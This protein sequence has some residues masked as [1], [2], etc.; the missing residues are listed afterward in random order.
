MQCKY[1]LGVDV[2][3]TKIAH[4]PH[5]YQECEE[6]R[7]QDP[8][9][10]RLP[11]LDLLKGFDAAA[12]HLSFTRAGEEL[13][14]TQSA[15]S[16]QMQTLE[17]QLGAPLFERRHRALRLTE[18]GQVLQLATRSVLDD[19]TRA[20][21]TIRRERS[22]A[23]LTISTAIPFAAL[24]LLP[25]LPRFRQIHP[26]VDVFI[27][28]DNRILDL[29]QERIDLAVRYCPEALAPR[30]AQRLFGERLQPVCS[31]ALASDPARPLKQPEDL[32]RHVLLN[33]DDDRGR[34]PWL[35]WTQWFAAI[36]V[37]EPRPAGTVRFNQYNLLVQAAI[38]GQGVA[39]GR[40][41]LVD[42][43]VAQ[44]KLVAPFRRKHATTRAYF[45]VRAAQAASR[46]EAQAFIDWLQSEA[47]EE[48]AEPA[49]ARLAP[50]PRSRKRKSP[51]P[52]KK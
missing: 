10:R 9:G 42:Q 31:P 47:H 38:D 18:A 15:L 11:S 25:R 41:P 26:E 5:A 52:S 27:S 17:E 50:T 51:S 8:P 7:K 37:P 3:Q 13:F 34:Y 33:L 45:I 20:V 43:L 12:R 46:P 32:A 29:D 16:R 44:G 1:R 24:W 19:L 48:T 21:T 35:N 40:S 23:P 4:G 30:D 2:G 14:L 28:A 36:G 6:M 22:V 49:E 39:L